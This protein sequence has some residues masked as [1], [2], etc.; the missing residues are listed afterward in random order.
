MWNFIGE[1]MV[2]EREASRAAASCT[3]RSSDCETGG[4]TVERRAG[5]GNM[6]VCVSESEGALGVVRVQTSEASV[7]E[8]RVCDVCVTVLDKT[9]WE[10]EE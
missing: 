9:G 8:V 2:S 4:C 7:V 1:R 10:V 6:V 3:T 5:V